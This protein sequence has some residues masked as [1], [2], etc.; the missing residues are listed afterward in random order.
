MT[1]IANHRGTETQRGPLFL[2]RKARIRPPHG[3]LTPPCRTAPPNASV[4]RS[5]STQRQALSDSAGFASSFDS[6]PTCEQARTR[7]D[8]RALGAP[9]GAKF[10]GD[11]RLRSEPTDFVTGADASR[12]FRRSTPGNQI[13]A[14]SVPLWFFVS[15]WLRRCLALCLCASVVCPVRWICV[16]CV[17]CGQIKFGGICSANA[18][19]TWLGRES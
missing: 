18:P 14:G 2:D 11:E 3:V 9:A 10:G 16:I 5:G 15:S 19:L 13:N 8:W 4:R 6:R 17:I 7:R 12:R 1:Q